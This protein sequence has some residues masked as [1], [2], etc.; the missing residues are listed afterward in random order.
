MKGVLGITVTEKVLNRLYVH[1]EEIQVFKKKY[2][3]L[4]T[5]QNL[6]KEI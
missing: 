4:L 5:N 2:Q 6:L 3:N 1:Q